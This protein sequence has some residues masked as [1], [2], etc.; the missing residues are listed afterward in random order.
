MSTI[1]VDEVNEIAWVSLD[2]L[3]GK[4]LFGFWLKW[5]RHFPSTW[6]LALIMMAS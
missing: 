6:R 2:S 3:T 1:F 4:I 5:L